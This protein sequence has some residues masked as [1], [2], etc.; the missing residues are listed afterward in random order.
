MESRKMLNASNLR[1]AGH[2]YFSAADAD[3]EHVVKFT[4]FKDDLTMRI[5]LEPGVVV[6]D[7][8]FFISRWIRQDIEDPAGSLVLAGLRAGRIIP[9]FRTDEHDFAGNFDELRRIGIAGMLPASRDIAQVLTRNQAASLNPDGFTWPHQSGTAFATAIRQHL[10]E[11]PLPDLSFQL[12]RRG[13][14]LLKKLLSGGNDGALRSNG[15]SKD[16]RRGDIFA[17][18]ALSLGIQGGVDGLRA[19]VRAG[20]GDGGVKDALQV[21]Y[22]WIN[23]LYHASQANVFGVRA[24]LPVSGRLGS[25]QIGQRLFDES[26]LGQVDAQQVRSLS[27][28][29]PPMVQ[30]RALAVDR[31]CSI[32]AEHGGTYRAALNNYL[33]YRGDRQWEELQNQLGEYAGALRKEV[34]RSGANPR[35]VAVNLGLSVGASAGAAILPQVLGGSMWALVSLV[36]ATPLVFELARSTDQIWRAKDRSTLSMLEASRRGFQFDLSVRL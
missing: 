35:Q 6:P 21:F 15:R 34:R 1:H 31:I 4:S 28:D 10:L 13:R 20:A 19:E 11:S 16:I 24:S 17:N 29:F 25:G 3:L 8:F 7:V 23:E 22:L 32:A 14:D 2:V 5:L 33:I 12:D 18:A 26:A 27:V 30:I 9:A 36:G